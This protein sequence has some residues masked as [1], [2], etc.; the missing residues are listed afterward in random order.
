MNNAAMTIFYVNKFLMLLSIYL[1]VELLEYIVYKFQV[2]AITN[3]HKFRV[4]KK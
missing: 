1:A 2:N 3:S 4:F